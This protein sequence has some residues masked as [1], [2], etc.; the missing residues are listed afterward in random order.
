MLLLAVLPTPHARVEL[1]ASLNH[2]YGP[3]SQ[4]ATPL[5]RKT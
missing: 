1:P 5:T 3:R 4:I 2:L